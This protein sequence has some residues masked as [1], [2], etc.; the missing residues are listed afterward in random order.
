[1]HSLLVRVADDGATGS[2]GKA[3]SFAQHPL[4]VHVD[5][6]VGSVALADRAGVDLLAAG[7]NR[8]AHEA[9]PA[10][11][12]GAILLDRRPR[13]QGGGV[14]EPLRSVGLLALIQAASE[15]VRADQKL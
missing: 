13:L 5:V 11:K 2:D 8:A 15:A 10:V 1:M 7:V 4:D 9:V 12:Q 6:Q 14:D 3:N